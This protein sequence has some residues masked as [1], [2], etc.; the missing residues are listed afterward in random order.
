MAWDRLR[1]TF[2][3]SSA[4]LVKIEKQFH[5]CSLEKRHVPGNWITEMEDCQMR[6]KEFGYNISDYQFILHRLNNMTNDYDYNL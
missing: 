1:N 4:S 6:P 2:D 3:P 5:Q